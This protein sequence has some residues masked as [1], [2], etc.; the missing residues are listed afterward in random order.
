MTG[1]EIVEPESLEEAFRLLDP[2]DP[3]VR[4]IGGGTALMLMMKAQIYKPERLVSLRRLDGRFSGIDIAADGS[5]FRIGAMTTF[6]MLEHSPAIR[7]HLPVIAQTMKTLA[8]VRVRNVASVGGNLAHADPHLDLPP[9][10]VALGARAVVVGPRGE[11]T[12]PVEAIFEG[13]YETS[14][15]NDELIAE[16]EVPVRAGWDALYV[17]VTTRAAHDWP[18][19]GLAV[20]AELEGRRIRDLRLVLS[21]AVDKPTRLAAAEAVLRGAEIG[22]ATLRAAGEAAVAETEIES[23]SRG[24]AAYKQHLLRVHLGRA[25]EALA[26]KRV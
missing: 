9:V 20:S 24:S 25:I 7:R 6:S 3:A 2:E 1:F 16:L 23:D 21:A 15:A 22:P 17:K 18:A 14:L 19:L 8:N 12:I 4:P 10:W 11:R 13:Y 26:A 5:G